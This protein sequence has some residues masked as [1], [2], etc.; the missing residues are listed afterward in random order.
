MR[1]LTARPSAEEEA[2]APHRLYGFLGPEESC[3]A[4]KWLR[5]A[6]MEIDW[7]RSQGKLPI[8][9]GGTGLY[10]NVLIN[11]MADIPDIDPAIRAQSM[12]DLQAMGHA[13][14]HERLQAVDP[15][16]GEKLRPSD[17]QRLVRA[18]E[19]WL[20][21]GKPLSWWQAQGSKPPYNADNFRLYNIDIPR[22]MLYGRCD[23]RVLIMLN[24]GAINEVKQLVNSN[25]SCES[26]LYKIIGIIEL[27]DFLN[28]QCTLEEATARMQ[29]ATRNY[30]KRQR[31]WFRHQLKGAKAIAPDENIAI[32]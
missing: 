32:S 19:V 6:Q 23:E 28:N 8:V 15:L 14:F 22:E 7:A 21:T 26:S 18:Y 25:I 20:G 29:Q 16:L 24:N 5:M 3:S 9:V 12:S 4:G 17:S 27:A 11:G 31:T 30:A 2:R 1:I 10:I 13:A